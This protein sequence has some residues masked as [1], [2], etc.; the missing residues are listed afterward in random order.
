M[1]TTLAAGLGAAVGGS[2]TLHVVVTFVLV[3]SATSLR[4]AGPR[5]ALL[6]FVISAV[7]VIVSGLPGHEQPVVEMARF[8]AGG[9]VALGLLLAVSRP[10]REPASEAPV[11]AL[12]GT[13]L[14]AHGLR[15]AVAVTV[16]TLVGE[17]ADLRF[18]YWVPLTTLAVLQPDHRASV[19]R[20]LQRCLGTVVGVAVVA[21]VTVATAEPSALIPL[22]GVSSFVLFAL[23]ERSY[24]WVVVALTPT[25]LLMISTDLDEGWVIAEQR[26]VDT[27]IGVAIALAATGLAL[28]AERHVPALRTSLE[29]PT[30]T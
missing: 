15:V 25:A 26:L 1:G 2:A 7:Y 30:S 23:R 18:A 14:V 10:G 29:T 12:P 13:V 9:V 6:G 5:G 8:A 4:R 16:A 21:A 17:A 19:V 27:L 11:A 22:V 28:L 3:G 24:Y 20:A